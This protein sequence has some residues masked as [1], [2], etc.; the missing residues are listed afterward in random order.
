MMKRIG[1]LSTVVVLL[2]L[3]VALVVVVKFALGDPAVEE[4]RATIRLLTRAA[5]AYEVRYGERPPS[6]ELVRTPPD[7]AGP[8][9]VEPVS[10]LDP[11]GR[12]YQ[13]D[14]AGPRNDGRKP[15]VWSR[16]P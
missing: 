7:G 1:R 2:A 9:S 16:G 8:G 12:E 14:P 3:A 11:W 15:D 10:L 4:A 6:L 13:Y 5:Q